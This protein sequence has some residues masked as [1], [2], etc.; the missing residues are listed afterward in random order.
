MLDMQEYT[1]NINFVRTGQTYDDVAAQ[2]DT[3][4]ILDNH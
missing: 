2:V 4:E 3:S 1:M